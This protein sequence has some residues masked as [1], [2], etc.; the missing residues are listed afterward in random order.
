[1]RRKHQ[2]ELKVF[3][4]IDRTTRTTQKRGHKLWR[5]P[6]GPQQQILGESSKKRESKNEIIYWM[7]FLSKF[8]LAQLCILFSN[9]RQSPQFLY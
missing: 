3:S 1:M 6:Y 8:G 2:F 4:V 9:P 5:A 7:F